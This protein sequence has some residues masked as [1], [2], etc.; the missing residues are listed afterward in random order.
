M[1]QKHV[2]TGAFGFSGR[3]IARRLLRKG[4][5]VVTLTDSGGRGNP[6]GHR[7]K[8]WPYNFNNL[9]E[10]SETL[11]GARV[12]YNNYWVRF[13]H[14]DFSYE[15]AVRNSVVLFEAAKQAGVGRIV[16]IS[17]TNPSTDSPYEYFRG[18]AL[19]ERALKDCGISYAILRPAVLFGR[20]DILV[21]NIAWILRRFP[22][23]GVFGDGRYRLQPIY[24]GDLAD[25]AVSKGEGTDDCII[26]AI[27]PQ[28]FTYRELVM[29]LKNIMGLHR[30]LV[31]IPPRIG[32][33]TGRLIGKLQDDV[34]ITYDEIK[35]L[36]DELLFTD[37]QPAG[38][39]RLT[40]WVRNNQAVVGRKYHH[41]LA[42]RIDRA[43]SYEVI[44]GLV[45]QAGEDACEEEE[46][47][48]A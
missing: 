44:D 46:I 29:D 27:G 32:H 9:K 20:E 12:L 22:V 24:V 5:E 40:E 36:M 43:S 26:D 16:H 38:K 3:Y 48:P 1:R 15:E 21:N 10:L 45:T 17:I 18:K 25:L 23:F 34:T 35:G 37:S 14:A 8:A 33:L 30:A 6:F 28:T 19:V 39:T 4:H 41:E 13:N 47:I 2:V 42:R 7:I 11:R 31:S